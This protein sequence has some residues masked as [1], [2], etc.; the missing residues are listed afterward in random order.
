MDS[1]QLSKILTSV[2]GWTFLLVV[3]FFIIASVILNYHWNKFEIDKSRTRKIKGV[4]FGI[5]GILLIIMTALFV[6]IFK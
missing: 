4:Y 5:S 2:A 3:L 1:Q 6:N